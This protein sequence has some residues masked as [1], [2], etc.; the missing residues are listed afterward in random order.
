MLLQTFSLQ[1]SWERCIHISVERVPWMEFIDHKIC[2]CS[3]VLYFATLFS[4]VVV[5]VF[6]LNGH[7]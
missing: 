4:K 1:V 3:A 7:V 6:A 5:P 2:T